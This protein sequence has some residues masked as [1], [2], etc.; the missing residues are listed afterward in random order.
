MNKQHNHLL[1][2]TRKSV[3]P[4]SSTLGF[5][6]PIFQAIIPVTIVEEMRENEDAHC[7]ARPSSGSI[8]TA[9]SAVILDR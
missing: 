8:L 7:R 2:G 9:G 5:T 3:A 1:I 4:H 6:K